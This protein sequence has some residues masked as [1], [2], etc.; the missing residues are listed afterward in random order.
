MYT[1]ILPKE[2]ASELVKLSVNVYCVLMVILEERRCGLIATS[3]ARSRASIKYNRKQDNIMIRPNRE[4]GA[5]IRLAAKLSG[6]SV[7]AYILGVLRVRMDADGVPET[8][9]P[10]SPPVE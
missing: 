2:N 3:E 10:P 4:D 8:V 6:Q 1:V 9:A 7:Q 5:R